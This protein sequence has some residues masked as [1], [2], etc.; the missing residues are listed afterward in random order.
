[1]P[2]VAFPPCAGGL[3]LG[4][5]S[6]MVVVN[7]GADVTRWLVWKWIARQ[8]S[9]DLGIISEQA[10]RKADKPEIMPI[11]AKRREPHLPIQPGLVRRRPMR[12]LIQIAGFPF[13]FVREPF[14]AVRTS[15]HNDLRPRFRHHAEQT[16]AAHNSK[17]RDI[18]VEYRHRTRPCRL[19]PE[20]GKNQHG[21]DRK[22]R[23]E[24]S[25]SRPVSA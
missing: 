25:H 16:V 7:G 24:S 12:R 21:V 5:R 8:Q 11:G 17:W 1:M 10:F 22:S 19:G 20:G 2:F 14:D 3:V 9:Q 18:I 13:E 15:F 6:E 23:E 4:P